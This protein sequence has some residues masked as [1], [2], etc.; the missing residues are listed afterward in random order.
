[1]MIAAIVMMAVMGAVL[2]ATMTAQAAFQA[3]GEVADMHQRLRAAVDR[4]AGDLRAASGVRPYRV[5]GARDDAAAGVYY[6]PDTISV[7]GVP[8]S[9]LSR[10]ADA[11]RTYYLKSDARANTFELMQ[12]DGRQTDLPFIEHVVA[13][14][15]EYFASQPSGAPL[16]RLDPALLTDGP[17]GEDALHRRFDLDLLHV[18]QIHV[19]LRVE[20]A[21]R[22]SRG[23]AAVLFAH[24]GTSNAPGRF[25]PDEAIELHVA[26]RHLTLQP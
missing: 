13:M 17:W 10:D 3:Q 4:I 24:P 8:S 5:G 26:P 21:D 2:S 6:R 22:S 15:V 16:S 25:V 12:F 9:A 7:L 23:S 1:M 18:G 11:T 19:Y 14:T 20:S